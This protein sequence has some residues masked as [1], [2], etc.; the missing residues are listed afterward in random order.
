MKGSKK[1]TKSRKIGNMTFTSPGQMDGSTSSHRSKNSNNMTGGSGKRDLGLKLFRASKD[2]I[3]AFSPP[4]MIGKNNSDDLE[5]YD[6]VKDM[7][8]NRIQNAGSRLQSPNSYSNRNEAQNNYM[9]YNA[10][11]QMTS[12]TAYKEQGSYPK[13]GNSGF[14]KNKNASNNKKK[15]EAKSNFTKLGTTFE[16]PKHKISI[17]GT[18]NRRNTNQLGT[19]DTQMVVDNI[20]PIM[21]SKRIENNLREGAISPSCGMNIY[22]ALSPGL[23]S[24]ID[25]QEEYAQDF[26]GKRKTRNKILDQFKDTRNAKSPMVAS[27]RRHLEA[28][29]RINDGYRRMKSPLPTKKTLPLIHQEKGPA[30]NQTI[31][32]MRKGNGIGSRNGFNNGANNT[33][34]PL[35]G[36]GMNP[37][38]NGNQFSTISPH[39]RMGRGS[40]SSNT[41]N[42]F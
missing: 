41:F 24:E 15:E 38:G 25:E 12:N 29:K 40:K 23:G 34:S 3:K 7:I 39:Q 36:I 28:K 14:K 5:D 32:G 33:I 16:R 8:E 13:R 19:I 4:P 27:G 10:V 18:N 22:R 17:V 20:T 42:C 1:N 11:D 30:R 2:K 37:I 31:M 35:E 9:N 6:S 21:S 26:Q